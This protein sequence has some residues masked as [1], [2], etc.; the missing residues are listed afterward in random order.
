MI[1][2]SIIKKSQ[3]EGA[4]R[5]DAEFFHPE[6][7]QAKSILEKLN[8]KSIADYFTNSKKVFNPVNKKLDTEAIVYDLTDALG[9]F[10]DSGTVVNSEK[11]IGSTKKIIEQKDVIISRL[12]SY[13]KEIAFIYDNNKLK[14]VSTEFVVL[15]SKEKKVYPEVLF[16]FLQTDIV[17]KILEWSQEGVNHPRFSENELLGL[18]F[19]DVLIKSQDYIKN[20]IVKSNE[21]YINSK[22]LY[23]Q[24]ENLLLE[25]LGLKNFSAEGGSVSDGESESGLWS[26]VNLSEVKKAKRID[27][28]YFQLKY[29]KLELRIRNY[30]SRILEKVI[31]NVPAKFDPT[32]QSEKLFKYVEL[33]N[34]NAS[35][36]IIDG[37]FEVLGKEAPDR[38]KRVLK[39]GDV[40]VSSVEGSLGK[41]ALAHKDQEN[42]L[43]STGFF[44]FRSKDI[45]PE[46]LLVL[47]KSIVFQWQLEKRCAGTILTAVPK[48]SIKDILVPILQKPIQ[49][50]IADLVQKSYESRKK[51]KEFLEEAKRKVEEMIEK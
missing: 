28:E 35:F 16:S 19:P 4:K 10:L 31:E 9:L 8:G 32:K 45:L 2:Y 34:I 1:T 23:S 30:E 41:V 7:L 24:A 44:Q 20:L 43:A 37:F 25:E 51:A 39:I 49:Q 47:A 18:R 29:E 38:A 22:S 13:L 36:G 14:L 46:V 5:L 17:Q 33:S 50:K 27:A 48:E 21:F 11:E 12:R 6:K 15:R 26:V 40:I 42:F 3:L